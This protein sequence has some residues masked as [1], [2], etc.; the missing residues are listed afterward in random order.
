MR[1]SDEQITLGDLIAALQK[2]PENV[3][4]YFDWCYMRPTDFNSYRGYYEDLA[5]GY[6]D[7][8]HTRVTAGELLERA[9]SA[10]GTY[11]EGYK[12]GDFK[13]TKKTVLWVANY[14]RS[15]GWAIVGIEA[16]EY[17]ITLKTAMI[18]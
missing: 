13:M 10:V 18:D 16:D 9:E 3:P 15:T 6:A 11:M 2:A 8:P 4:V 14:G 17:S 7:T 12:G 1:M 5:L